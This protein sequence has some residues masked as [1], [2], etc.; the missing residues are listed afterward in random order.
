MSTD[1]DPRPGDD[2]FPDAMNRLMNRLKMNGLKCSCSAC[3]AAR[4]H[5]ARE[6][7]LNIRVLAG[8]IEIESF[9]GFVEKDWFVLYVNTREKYA[10]AR[11]V[12]ENP[13]RVHVCADARTLRNGEPAADPSDAMPTQIEIPGDWFAEAE[14]GRYSCRITG[15]RRPDPDLMLYDIPFKVEAP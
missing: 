12:G 7:D 3:T 5:G 15:I 13:I 10:D 2:A 8:Q 4:A 11:C 1:R 9:S 14:G 6:P